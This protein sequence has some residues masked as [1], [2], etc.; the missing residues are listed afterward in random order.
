MINS[1]DIHFVALKKKQQL[2]IK[3]QIGSFICNSRAVG[4]EANNLLKQMNFS[5]SFA[6]NYDLFGIIS[7]TG[8]KQ[9]NSPYAHIQNP[10][11]EQFMNQTD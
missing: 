11:I 7:E 8:I 4:E 1:N 6:W 9:R 5:L 3:S 2:R 10:E